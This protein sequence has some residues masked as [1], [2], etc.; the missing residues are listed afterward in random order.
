MAFFMSDDDANST[1]LPHTTTITKMPHNST[2]KDDDK[3]KFIYT[4][5]Y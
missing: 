5:Y 2:G 3:L 4:I 1:T